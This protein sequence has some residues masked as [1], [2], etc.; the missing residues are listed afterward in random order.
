MRRIK[1]DQAGIT[2]VF[3]PPSLKAGWALTLVPGIYNDRKVSMKHNLSPHQ[4]Q[5][6][7]MTV[8]SIALAVALF[9]GLL[10]LFNR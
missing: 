10:Y 3:S 2:A 1:F 6:R 4:K 7:F 5:M 8:L 9:V